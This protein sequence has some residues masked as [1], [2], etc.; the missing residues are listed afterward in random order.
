MNNSGS[1]RK[2]S[3][4]SSC[5]ILSFEFEIQFAEICVVGTDGRLRNEILIT[6]GGPRT[7]KYCPYFI[8]VGIWWHFDGK[9]VTELWDV[10]FEKLLCWMGS[11]HA[12][13]FLIVKYTREKSACISTDVCSRQLYESEVPSDKFWTGMWKVLHKEVSTV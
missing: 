3:F 11:F 6:A 2:L 5:S 8:S 9:L 7:R 10:H 13:F 1:L 4:D 12:F